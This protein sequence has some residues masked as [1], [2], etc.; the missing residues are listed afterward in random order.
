MTVL[1]IFLFLLSGLGL[2]LS[3]HAQTKRI[4]CGAG[5]VQH[6]VSGV[7]LAAAQPVG[8][9]IEFAGHSTFLITSP[10]GVRMATDYN[11]Y[12][13]AAVLPHIAA[14]SAWHSNHS[15]PGI[16]PFI[17]HA[18]VGWDRGE[19]TPRHDVTLKD[20]RVYNVPV[21]LEAGRRVFR[22]STSV[23]VVE[24]QGLCVAH[25]GLIGHVLEPRTLARIGRIDVMMTPIDLRVTQSFEEIIKNIQG[26][27][28]KLVIPMHYNARAKVEG[29][30]DE[31]KDFFP[32][33][34]PGTGTYVVRKSTLPKKTEILYLVPPFF[35]QGF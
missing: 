30:L 19:G 29:F 17:I 18:P 28:P 1:R 11:D 9:L 14:M 22:Y 20:M 34:R 5:L 16:S 7:I 21:N 25:L 33:R 2:A 24:S 35:S 8:L 12:Y 27:N 13:R 4:P 6:T 32:I 10:K 26:I 23:F 31:A 3:A 15:T